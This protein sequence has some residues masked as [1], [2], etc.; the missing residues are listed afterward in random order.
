MVVD[1]YLTAEEAQE[2]SVE[3]VT[4]EEAFSSGYV[5]SNHLPDFPSLKGI[6]NRQL[7]LSMRP[8]AT[9]INTG[10]G[11]QVSE[12]DLVEV[13]RLRP[14]LTALLDVTDPEPPGA[15]CPLHDVPNIHLSSHIAGANT[16]KFCASAILS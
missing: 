3:L 10:R 7:F 1:P 2:L 15:D 14:D 16:M 9:F 4:M 6:L 8:H 12:P 11:A 5:V 13:A